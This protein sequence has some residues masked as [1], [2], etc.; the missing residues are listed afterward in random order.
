[1]QRFRVVDGLAKDVERVAAE[2]GFSGVVRVD[3]GDLTELAVAARV[4]QCDL[5]VP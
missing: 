3:R 1:M 5:R 2:T 4:G